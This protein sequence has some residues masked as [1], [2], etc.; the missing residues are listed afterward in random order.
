MR[1][2]MGVEG[3]I[4]RNHE[5]FVMDDVNKIHKIMKSPIEDNIPFIPKKE[6]ERVRREKVMKNFKKMRRK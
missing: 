1:E 4:I 2:E 3:V 5:S 6:D